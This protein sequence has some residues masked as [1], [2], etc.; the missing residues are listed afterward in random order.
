MVCDTTT[1]YPSWE[2]EI[3]SS[4]A[5]IFFINKNHTEKCSLH[6]MPKICLKSKI[7]LD[8]TPSIFS[9]ISDQLLCL[10]CCFKYWSNL[11][12]LWLRYQEQRD[13]YFIF[14]WAE[15]FSSFNNVLISEP[16]QW[17]P[18]MSE[19]LRIYTQ[20]R[21]HFF[22]DWLWNATDRGETASAASKHDIISQ[23]WEGQTLPSKTHKP[24]VWWPHPCAKP[25]FIIWLCMCLTP[26][27]G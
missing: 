12:F 8:L 20:N 5:F 4:M 10:N 24:H 18:K 27:W 26:C 19:C 16:S 21:A 15:G 3:K 22:M 6:K 13:N 2:L 23:T 7:D 17:L 9:I 25:L 1:P 14:L 11:C